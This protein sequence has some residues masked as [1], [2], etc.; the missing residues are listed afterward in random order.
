MRK[1]EGFVTK[2]EFLALNS[3]D[4]EIWKDIKG[5]EGIYMISTYGRVLS[6]PIWRVIKSNKSLKGEFISYKNPHI[7]LGNKERNNYRR[8]D[9][10]CEGKITRK[11]VHRLVAEAFIPNPN[12]YPIINHK[13]ENPSNNCVDNLEWCTQ[14]ENNAYGTHRIRQAATQRYSAPNRKEVVQLSLNGELISRYDSIAFASEAT[15]IPRTTID[16]GILHKSIVR[17]KFRWMYLSDYEKLISM[18]KNS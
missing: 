15:G 5:Y 14:A 10:C 12:N 6:V 3:L 13:D 17:G 11:F 8:M 1:T 7:T 18:S 16:N 2:E 9:L 4:G